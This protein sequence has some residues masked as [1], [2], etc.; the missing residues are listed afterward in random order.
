ME[1][2]NDERAIIGF[3]KDADFT[4]MKYKEHVDSDQ[5]ISTHKK[6]VE[7]LTKM[8]MYSGKHLVDTKVLKTVS[9]ESQKWVAE[10]VIPL[11]QQ[12]SKNSKA[13]IALILSE[14]VFGSFAVKNISKKADAI[15]ETHFF[16]NYDEAI[17]FLKNS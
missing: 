3:D 16:N 12:K 10:N 8:D 17:T 13:K 14:D 15:S 1:F 4:F 11:I 5:F 2:Y 9:L 7:M 6:V